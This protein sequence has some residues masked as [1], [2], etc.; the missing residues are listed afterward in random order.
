MIVKVMIRM[1]TKTILTMMKATLVMMISV[2]VMVIVVM[3][4]IMIV[5]K[6]A[7]HECQRG[8]TIKERIQNE[9]VALFCALEYI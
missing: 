5:V 4:I 2:I 8:Q 3:M 9:E 7:I 6:K 1:I